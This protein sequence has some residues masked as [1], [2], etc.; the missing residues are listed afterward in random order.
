MLSRD[1]LFLDPDGIPSPGIG[2]SVTQARALAERLLMLASQAETVPET[3]AASSAILVVHDGTTRGDRAFE[4]AFTMARD[5]D[6]LFYLHVR[7]QF[8][9]HCPGDVVEQ[10]A[11]QLSVLQDVAARC[12]KQAARQRVRMKPRVMTIDEEGGALAPPDADIDFLI[13][14]QPDNSSEQA[15]CPTNI[16][17]YTVFVR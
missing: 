1:A 12:A 14:P 16:G 13:L 7:D 4:L 3:A 11:R 2:L 5:Y 6:A 8:A 17:R 10:C 9:W 15:T